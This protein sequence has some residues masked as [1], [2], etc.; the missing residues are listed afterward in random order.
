MSSSPPTESIADS[1][2]TRLVEAMS[3]KLRTQGYHGTG[4]SEILSSANVPKGVLY[5]HFPSGK[6]ELAAHAIAQSAE[7]VRQT[8]LGGI[9]NFGLIGMLQ[10]LL[11]ASI[12]RAVQSNFLAG[13]PIAASTM[14]AAHE[15]VL[16]ESV[17]RAFEGLQVTLADALIHEGLPAARASALANLLLSNY[18]GSMLLL[19][20]HREVE[21]V[22]DSNLIV[23]KLIEFE[24]MNHKHAKLRTRKSPK[25]QIKPQINAQAKSQAKS[26]S[27]SQAKLEN[28]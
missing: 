27:Q 22:E 8:M 13:C 24:L 18:Q 9:Q 2:K 17:K 6:A 10:R 15:P 28:P 19:R 20:A 4:I 16:Q 23:M 3:S 1:T 12:E 26:Q 14:D 25:P 5:H 11:E 7:R 21:L